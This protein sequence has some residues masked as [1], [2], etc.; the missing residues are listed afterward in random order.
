MSVHECM[1][2]HRN[3]REVFC[4]LSFYF[5]PD[6]LI[7]Y[8]M[9]IFFYQLYIPVWDVPNKME[10]VHWQREQHSMTFMSNKGNLHGMIIFTVR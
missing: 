6:F 2:L 10:M 9:E 7:W 5:Y 4:C 8:F 1:Y 3:V